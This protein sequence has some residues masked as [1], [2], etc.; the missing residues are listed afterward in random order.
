MGGALAS[1]EHLYLSGNEIGYHGMKALA[2]SVE[3]GGLAAAA[4]PELSSS[5]GGVPGTRDGPAMTQR[6]WTCVHESVGSVFGGAQSGCGGCR[7]CVTAQHS[8]VRGESSCVSLC[9]CLRWRWPVLL[10]HAPG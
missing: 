8:G 7:L 5:E 1:L 10:S 3:R 6:E 4:D 9:V 2:D